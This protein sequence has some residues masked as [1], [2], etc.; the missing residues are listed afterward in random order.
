M[1]LLILE[2]DKLISTLHAEGGPLTVGSSPTSFVHLDDPR[3]K[4]HQAS[5]VKHADGGWWLEVHD[6]NRPT[7]LNR[8]VQRG[9]T[10]LRD[11]DEIEMED[12][13]VRLFLEQGPNG[14]DLQRQRLKSL[15][16]THGDSLPLGSVI[17]KKD[18]PFLLSRQHVEQLTDLAMD[19]DKAATATDL[20]SPV[21]RAMIR[22]F[23]G[24]RAW[25]GFRRGGQGDFDWSL[26][27]SQKGAPCP[28]P[29][30]ADKMR[31]RCL[32]KG[33]WVCTPR[34]HVDGVG[35]AMAAPV[36]RGKEILGMIY[37]EN[38]EADP[39]YDELDLGVLKALACSVARPLADHLHSAVAK[40][41]AVFSTEQTVAR[42]IQ[43][44][45]TPEALP[46]WPNFQAAAFRHT[47]SQHCSD[48][49]DV[50]QLRDKSAAILVARLTAEGPTLP[51]LFA[52]VRTAFR[53]AVLH[54][55]TPINFM[56][57]FNWL[58]RSG[59]R[60]PR[61]ADCACVWCD[62]ASGEVHFCSAGGRVVLGRIHADGTCEIVP[63]N[64]LPAVGSEESPA[65]TQRKFTLASGDTLVLAT[66][67][68]KTA[69]NA[70]GEAL[71]LEGLKNSLCDG[72]GDTPG[73]VLSEFATDL[74]DH[75]EAG[76]CPDDVTVFLLRRE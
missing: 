65:L 17:L 68:P 15:T 37:V 28:R 49:Y 23:P 74:A 35:S 60:S 2:N 20:M 51:K 34:V 13:C 19:M 26:G 10:Q 56:R 30:F 27:W 55:D 61:T 62:H 16:K 72:L 53:M 57:A 40:K 45:L 52:E 31:A 3:I 67:G 7:H 41:Q 42:M 66:D 1:R 71:G 46:R 70:A 25:V 33:H 5:I 8:A 32:T 21:L 54:G 76:D 36:S 58:I 14:A 6:L 29:A 48:F 69:T 4:S 44:A 63:G 50:M 9:R 59:S 12:Y 64:G 24:R 39:P 18:D 22:V 73:H 38:D 43:D 75:C 47:G 11:A